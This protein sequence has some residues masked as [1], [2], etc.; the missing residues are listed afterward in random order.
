[1]S[2]K[3]NVIIITTDQQRYDSL[4]CLHTSY[5]KTPNIDRMAGKG[6]VFERTYCTNPTCTPS[7]A[8]IF[9]GKYTSGHGAWSVGVNIPEDTVF[10][11]HRFK[12]AGYRTHLI[13]KAHFNGF[14]ETEGRSHEE[15]RS[16]ERRF[17]QF[18]GPYYGFESVEL[19][20]G[21]TTFGIAGH[22]GSW[23]KEKSG[24]QNV[25]TFLNATM[26]ADQK[27]G[28][29]AY[30]WDIPMEL[31]NN[32]WVVEKSIEFL[33]NMA[34]SG[35]PF[36]LSIGFQ[37][38]H[39][40]HAVP[41]EY[42][43]KID[44]SL[45]TLPDFEQGELDDKPGYFRQANRGELEKSEWKRKYTIAG[46]DPSY[47]YNTVSEK[48]ARL[49]KAYYYTMVEM[50][51]TAMGK[52]MDTIENLGFNENT[53]IVFTTD[54][55]ELLGD[56]GIWMKGPFHYE[57]LIKVPLIIQYPKLNHSGRRVQKLVSQVDIA[58]T[59][60]NECGLA[61]DSSLDGVDL[62]DYL[63]DKISSIHDSVFVEC[64]DDPSGI[65]LKTIITE[66]YKLT[67]HLGQCLGELYDLE[68]DTREKIN[69]WKHVAYAD[70]RQELLL[71]II[72]FGERLEK[73][74]R[75]ERLCYA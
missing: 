50:I 63:D 68:N 69:L 10:L 56:H 47:N 30:D 49:G 6:V 7:R 8:S 13:G 59:L 41:S 15:I 42:A 51:D 37:D 34:D 52:I 33:R 45:M 24:I 46:Q 39:H 23:I 27:F 58:P 43:A 62:G 12:E 71:R 25:N 1:M 44:P 18:G 32:S 55:G 11:S 5:V 19:S 31:H 35:T 29:E 2:M 53:V 70:V 61:I 60:L 36:F 54:H 22:Y 16:W 72:E 67:C 65:R 14:G 40:P 73:E 9:S 3:K 20:M 66:R 4:G 28:G 57:Q 75:A 48:D 64:I 21:H 26:M 38:P 17:P 74:K